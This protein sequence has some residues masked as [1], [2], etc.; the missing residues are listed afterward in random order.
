MGFSKEWEEQYSSNHHMSIWPWS[1]LVSYIYRYTE[2][3]KRP[4]VKVLEIGCGAGANIRLFQELG[5]DY[6]AM[7][8]SS[9]IV[10]M[11]QE[12]YPV[13]AKNL[14]VGDFTKEIPFGETFDVIVDR[15]ALTHNT[16]VDIKKTV[17]LIEEHLSTGGGQFIGID[18][19]SKNHDD[20]ALGDI[21]ANDE[22]TKF[23]G[24]VDGQFAGVGNVHF[25]DEAHLREL[26]ANFDIKVMEEKVVNTLLPFKHRFASWNFVAV[27]KD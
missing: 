13:Y 24:E 4:K 14:A 17:K 2:L 10:K 27:K 22:Y 12:K 21:L 23:M 20:F 1:D 16:T 15:A 3:A 5:A 18:W 19:F 6:Y 25:S 8:G 11:L 9:T 7:D 26:F